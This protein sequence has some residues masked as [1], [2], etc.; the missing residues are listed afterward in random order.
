M[1]RHLYHWQVVKTEPSFLNCAHLENVESG[2]ILLKMRINFHFQKGEDLARDFSG[3]WQCKKKIL[4]INGRGSNITSRALEHCR[5]TE[6]GGKIGEPGKYILPTYIHN[7][8][9]K[10]IG[11]LNWKLC[12][13]RLIF[14]AIIMVFF[15]WTPCHLTIFKRRYY[16]DKKKRICPFSWE[17]VGNLLFISNSS[18]MSVSCLD[19]M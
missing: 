10:I 16:I 17:S 4:C 13:K 1:I 5:Q 3:F 12:S 2:K 18:K 19:I 7:W 9:W 8:I 15:N 14:K 11:F 6:R